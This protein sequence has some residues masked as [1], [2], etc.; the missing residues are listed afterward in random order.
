MLGHRRE[1]CSLYR[2]HLDLPALRCLC[3]LADGGRGAGAVYNNGS[4]VISTA[5][6]VAHRP[7]HSAARACDIT[8]AHPDLR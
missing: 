1:I 2:L 4:V 3:A 8:P 7:D 6:Q 5:P